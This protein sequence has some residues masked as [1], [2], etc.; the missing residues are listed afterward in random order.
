VDC[1]VLEDAMVYA[2]FKYI[3]VLLYKAD[4]R[5]WH[6]ILAAIDF[7]VLIVAE[8]SVK[9]FL[10]RQWSR[11][12]IFSQTSLALS[13]KLDLIS[14]SLGINES[15]ELEFPN[16]YSKLTKSTISL[17]NSVVLNP[18]EVPGITEAVHF[19]R[20]HCSLASVRK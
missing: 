12:C 9:I 10:L 19:W 5:T 4:V 7:L 14:A 13:H 8:P 1:V 6:R 20:K 2:L 18:A 15:E 3:N 17:F 16:S 11:W